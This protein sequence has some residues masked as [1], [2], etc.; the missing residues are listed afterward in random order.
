MKIFN[1][2][3]QN[4]AG[5]P[6]KGGGLFLTS[7]KGTPYDANQVGSEKKKNMSMYKQIN[8]NKNEGTGKM[9]VPCSIWSNFLSVVTF[10]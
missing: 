6:R 7:K 9:L 8:A 5:L 4:Q 2:Y 3:G 1:V 10:G